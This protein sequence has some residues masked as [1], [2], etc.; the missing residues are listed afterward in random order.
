MTLVREGRAPGRSHAR[1]VARVASLV[2]PSVVAALVAALV[3]Q[4]G[5][6]PAVTL[7]AFAVG[8]V[9]MA[10]CLRSMASR[11]EPRGKVR[12]KRVPEGE[13][14]FRQG[15]DATL[16]ASRNLQRHPRTIRGRVTPL[17]RTFRA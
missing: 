11:G 1:Q 13:A 17:P 14:F 15:L 3:V 10:Y 7:L 5:H 2:L 12:T 9:G 16:P 6:Y 8:I 4:G